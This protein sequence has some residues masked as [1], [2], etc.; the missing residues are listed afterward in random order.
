MKFSLFRGARTWCL[1][2]IQFSIFIGGCFVISAIEFLGFCEL[3]T[4]PSALFRSHVILDVFV[5]RTQ[6]ICLQLLMFTTVIMH[7][8]TIFNLFSQIVLVSE[9]IIKWQRISRINDSVFEMFLYYLEILLDF[10]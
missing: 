8:K 3:R 6:K 9:T 5:L 4:V 10:Y 7:L 1:V 2:L